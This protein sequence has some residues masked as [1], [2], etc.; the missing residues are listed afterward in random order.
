MAFLI[1]SMCSPSVYTVVGE[2]LT[3]H[4]IYLLRSGRYFRTSRSPWCSPCMVKFF[5]LYPETPPSPWFQGSRGDYSPF[6]SLTPSSVVHFSNLDKVVDGSEMASN[7]QKRAA[8]DTDEFEPSNADKKK[9]R[10]Q[11]RNGAKGRQ[12]DPDP[13]TDSENNEYDDSESEG[14]MEV[15]TNSDFDHTPFMFDITDDM[16]TFWPT[17]AHALVA[18]QQFYGGLEIRVSKSW[19]GQTIIHP[20]SNE[21]SFV[22]SNMHCLNGKPISF[23]KLDERTHFVTAILCKVPHAVTDALIEQ[24]VPNVAKA[25]RLTV[26]SSQLD[27]VVPTMSV[28]ILWKEKTIPHRVQIGFLGR[29]E[30]KAWTPEPSQCYKCQKFGHI[31]KACTALHPRCR[32][33]GETHLSDVCQKRKDQNLEVKVKCINCGEEHPASSKRCKRRKAIAQTLIEKTPELPRPGV[34]RPK[35]PTSN[36]FPNTVRAQTNLTRD[37]TVPKQ[38]YATA[39]KTVVKTKPTQVRTDTVPKVLDAQP[40]AT[41]PLTNSQRKKQQKLAR[42]QQEQKEK[43]IKEKEEQDR[44]AKEKREKKQ[45]YEQ[46]KRERETKENRERKRRERQRKIKIK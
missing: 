40:Q 24:I 5:H 1:F 27:E 38:G 29:F 3:L 7:G 15:V 45:L 32:L 37:A 14:D 39:L 11:N 36:D 6:I 42:L 13:L 43:E 44:K 25:T 23:M 46:K 22:I 30:T 33:C 12:P 34:K 21:A 35:I 4:S 41:T 10:K 16:K 31:A 2:F 26:Y 8:S 17:E 28:R 20:L 18:L 19:K 9:A